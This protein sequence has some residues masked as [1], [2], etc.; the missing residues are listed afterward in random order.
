MIL[1]SWPLAG[2]A[3]LFKVVN[4]FSPRFGGVE[5]KDGLGIAS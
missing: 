2:L 5:V 3:L 1:L 4:K